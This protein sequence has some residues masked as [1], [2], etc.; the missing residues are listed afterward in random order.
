MKDRNTAFQDDAEDQRQEE[1]VQEVESRLSRYVDGRGCT[2]AFVQEG[3]GQPC[4]S[5]E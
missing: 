3:L 5:R 4:S 1:R 2:P